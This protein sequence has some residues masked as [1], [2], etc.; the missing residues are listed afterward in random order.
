V[1][2]TAPTSR[3]AADWL[4]LSLAQGK[5]VGC[6]YEYAVGHRVLARIISETQ[7]ALGRKLSSVLLVEESEKVAFPSCLGFVVEALCAD[8][9]M[10]L[11]RTGADVLEEVD[12][13]YDLAVA[14]ASHI[15][16]IE[17]MRIRRALAGSCRRLVV[18][19]DNRENRYFTTLRDCGGV[20]EDYLRRSAAIAWGYLDAP[21]WPY[22]LTMVAGRELGPVRRRLVGIATQLL[23][24]GW[25]PFEMSLPPPV[26][27][28]F[29]HALY[30]VYEPA[31][32]APPTALAA[33]TADG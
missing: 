18:M 24:R 20:G 25:L 14:P 33:T 28:H 19:C 17:V 7:R 3:A 26:R 16:E 29:A 23:L 1:R 2:L 15:D 32:S 30:A 6:A 21:P 11:S 8:M 12:G 5:G 22:R 27:K 10:Q 4:P 9:G 31:V 13:P